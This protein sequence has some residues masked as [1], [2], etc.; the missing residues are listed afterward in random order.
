MSGLFNQLTLQVTLFKLTFRHFSSQAMWFLKY[1][2]SSFIHTQFTFA[3]VKIQV[4][5]LS[6]RL[7][8]F[9]QEVKLQFAHSLFVH[10]QLQRYILF[11]FRPKINFQIHQVVIQEVSK[12]HF[13]CV[14]VF[15]YVIFLNL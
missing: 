6:L 10:D 15:L 14:P 13:S 1:N 9:V 12:N 7:Q 4:F 8:Y 3:Q 11:R 5:E 2:S